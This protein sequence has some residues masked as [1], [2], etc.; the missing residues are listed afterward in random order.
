MW[1]AYGSVRTDDIRNLGPL[2]ERT[3]KTWGKNKDDVD[4]IDGGVYN[5]DWEFGTL[6]P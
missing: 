3:T 5:A 1:G 6:Y 4:K 2:Q